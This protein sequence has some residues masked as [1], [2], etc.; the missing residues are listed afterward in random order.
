MKIETGSYK[1]ILIGE[2][3]KSKK[4]KIPE[5]IFEN[6]ILF[7]EAYIFGKI[8]PKNKIKRVATTI[9]K[10]NFNKGEDISWKRSFPIEL[11]KI[12]IAMLMRLFVINIVANNLLGFNSKRWIVFKDEKLRL[13]SIC[14]FV[15]ENNATSDPEIKADDINNRINIR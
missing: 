15:K 6:F 5:I 4:F 9:S 13:S 11:N 8:S 10:I 3:K 14:F 1:W 2:K 7:L 12:T